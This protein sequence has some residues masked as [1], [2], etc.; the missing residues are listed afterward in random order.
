MNCNINVI[1]TKKRD[2]TK[3]KILSLKLGLE[4]NLQRYTRKLHMLIRSNKSKEIKH[5]THQVNSK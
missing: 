5:G 1:Q 3:N 2:T 4:N